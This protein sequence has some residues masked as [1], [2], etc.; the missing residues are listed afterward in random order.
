METIVQALQNAVD[1]QDKLAMSILLKR[2]D[3]M[4]YEVRFKKKDS[5]LT[6]LPK[7]LTIH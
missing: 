4:G 2:L 3:D 1:T 7:P 6:I 5:T